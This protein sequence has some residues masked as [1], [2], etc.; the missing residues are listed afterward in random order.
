MKYH[1]LIHIE[2]SSAM[3]LLAHNIMVAIVILQIVMTQSSA[4][5]RIEAG[6]GIVI[7]I[8]YIATTGTLT[9]APELCLAVLLI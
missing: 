9:A 2:G 1:I 6:T 7:N 4:N 8:I 3:H 5:M